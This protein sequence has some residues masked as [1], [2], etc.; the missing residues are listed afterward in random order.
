MECEK[1]RDDTIRQKEK[2]D[3]EISTIVFIYFPVIVRGLRW[4][5][6][7]R[8]GFTPK[9]QN[10]IRSILETR[11]EQSLSAYTIKD[12]WK[13]LVV[14]INSIRNVRS[15]ILSTILSLEKCICYHLSSAISSLTDFSPAWVMTV[16][17]LAS[18][19]WVEEW[20]PQMMTFFTSLTWMF[21][22]C[23]IQPRARL[24]SSLVRHVM[25]F[26]GMAGENSFRIRA[27]VL[28]GLATTRTWDEHKPISNSLWVS[29]IS[30]HS[31][32]NMLMDNRLS[33][34]W[35]GPHFLF[36]K[37]KSIKIS[38][39]YKKT[40]V[41]LCGEEQIHWRVGL[42][43]IWLV[44]LLQVLDIWNVSPVTINYTKL[45]IACFDF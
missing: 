19:Y 33:F 28:A 34:T 29:Q 24:W 40:Y 2:D 45:S 16:A 37:N 17:W 4:F 10:L 23:A 9:G 3:G 27:L 5:L 38:W 22:L 18:G 20:F 7:Q 32:S 39:F 11:S 31:F 12:I 26:A 25:F 43:A 41:S 15:V 36:L 30:A 42:V 14:P 44:L 13:A 8:Q 6:F 35:S 1:R 21:N